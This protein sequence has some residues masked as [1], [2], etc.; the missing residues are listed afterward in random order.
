MII[1]IVIIILIQKDLSKGT[2]PSNYRPITCHQTY[3]K[4]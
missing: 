4:Y 2:I 3:G 1:I